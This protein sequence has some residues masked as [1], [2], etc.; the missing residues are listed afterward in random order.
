MPIS[1]TLKY[2]NVS[3]RIDEIVSVGKFKLYF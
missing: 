1:E 2:E 3:L